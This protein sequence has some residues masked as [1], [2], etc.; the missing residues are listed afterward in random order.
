MNIHE[1]IKSDPNEKPLDRIVTDGGF[2]SIFRTVACIGDSLSS[3]EFESLN[4]AGQK[5]YHDYFEYSWGQYIARS[6]GA[7]V[8]N[9]S[10]GGMT[11]K[12]YC[13]SFAR[14]MDFW[15]P[16]K[17]CQ[18]YIMA[19]GVN[20]ILNQKQQTGSVDDICKEDYTQNKKSFAGYYAQI[21][22]RIKSMQP[23]A[24]FFFMTFPND[25]HAD[26][27]A[28]LQHRELMYALAEYFEYSYVIDLYQYAPVYDD[29]FKRR[30]YLGG[31]LNAAGYALTARMVESYID[32][33]VRH[34]PEDFAQ[35]GFIGKPFHN[36]GAK[37]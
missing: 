25:G 19:L 31:H 24:K 1:Y 26:Q 22:Q 12:A 3:G 29:E 4:E 11:A 6:T 35:V 36:V 20:D 21:V 7:T 15:N 9:F 14:D 27:T 18:A 34:N 10:K 13:E 33:I 23:K 5:G 2:C 28:V 16:S 32:F 17:L 8:Y 37:W 30:F